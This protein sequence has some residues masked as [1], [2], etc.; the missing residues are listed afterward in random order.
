MSVVTDSVGTSGAALFIAVLL[1]AISLIVVLVRLDLQ[2]PLRRLDHAVA[3]MSEGNFYAP[4][5]KTPTDDEISR[6]SQSFEDMRGQLRLTLEHSAARAQ[7]ASELNAQQP[8]NRAL[9]NVC[10][11]LKDV[12]EAESVFLLIAASEIADAFVVG[13]GRDDLPDPDDALATVSPLGVLMRA[14]P[15]DPVEVM[16]EG[17][18]AL[19]VTV[20]LANHRHGVLA[21]VFSE[22]VGRGSDD[23]SLMG[24]AAGQIALALERYRFIVMVQEQ[25]TMDDL[26]GLHNHRFLVDH[27][28]QQVALAERLNS[29]L[30]LL[31]LDLDHFK[32]LNDTYGH[33]AGDA[34]LTAFSAALRSN[35]RR[36]DLAARY[37]GEEFVVVMPGATQF[38]AGIVAEKFVRP[39]H[40]SR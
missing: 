33:A 4:I 40:V 6:L 9:V 24:M 7:V 25:A 36:S 10:A 15:L 1:I 39:C 38:D 28:A 32:R 8:L 5:P 13:V 37:G 3:A 12:T 31:M 11:T 30:A 19:A 18:S 16:I 29:P 22:G 35:I 20:Q 23:H 34:A 26:T 2:Q 17:K 27:I 21:A 14:G